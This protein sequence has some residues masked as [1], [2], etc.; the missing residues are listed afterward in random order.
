[1]TRSQATMVNYIYQRVIAFHDHDRSNTNRSTTQ[2]YGGVC[3]RRESAATVHADAG[4]HACR[5]ESD[6]ETDR[7]A[8]VGVPNSRRTREPPPA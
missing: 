6:S 8:R 2:V 4:H 7:Q 3:G 5:S 1:M